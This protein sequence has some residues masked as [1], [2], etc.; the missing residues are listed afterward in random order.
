MKEMKMIHDAAPSIR[1]LRLQEQSRNMV[2]TVWSIDA[3]W[4]GIGGDQEVRE[5]YRGQ[6]TTPMVETD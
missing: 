5:V 3:T 1:S 4:E 2:P 6:Y